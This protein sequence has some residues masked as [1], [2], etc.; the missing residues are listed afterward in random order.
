MYLTG[1]STSNFNLE[2]MREAAKLFEGFHDFRTF[3]ATGK[4]SDRITR[5]YLSSVQIIERSK[6]QI[7]VSWP[8]SWPVACDGKRNSHRILDM[9]FKGK[10]FL[11]KQV[12]GLIENTF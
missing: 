11:Y 2:T 4:D 10:G 9:Y 6:E 1:F 3:M 7:G 8:Y 12:S 5:K